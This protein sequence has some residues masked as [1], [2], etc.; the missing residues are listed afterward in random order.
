[1]AKKQAK[2][3]IGAKVTLKG[4]RPLKSGLKNLREL[5]NKNVYCLISRT[6]W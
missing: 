6:R 2:Q 4:L 3:V 1:M 5:L